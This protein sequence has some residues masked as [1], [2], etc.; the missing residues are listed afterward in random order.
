MVPLAEAWDAGASSRTAQRREAYANDQG[1][2]SSL[3][4][5]TGAFEPADASKR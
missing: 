4:A 2:V 1:Q 3:V 5:V